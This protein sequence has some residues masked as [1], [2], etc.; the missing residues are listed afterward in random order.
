MKINQ[1]PDLYIEQYLLGELPENLR[2]EIDE[3]MQHS[4]ELKDRIS[5]MEKSNQDILSVYPADEIVPGIIEKN[6]ISKNL[7]YGYSKNQNRNIDHKSNGVIKNLSLS[8]KKFLHTTS[9]ISVRR[10]TL[11]IA[12][13]AMMIA[14]IVF[15]LPGIRGIYNTEKNYDDTIRIKG[16]ESKLLLYRMKGRD[17]EE[18]KNFDT[19]QQGDV[20]QVGYIA[21]GNFNYGV[22]LSIDGRGTVTIHLPQNSVPGKSLVMNKRTLL[23]K[24]YELDDSPSF[25]RFIMILSPDPISIDSVMEKAKKLAISRESALNGSIDEKKGSIEFSITINKP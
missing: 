20:I 12:S 24:S 21:A 5:E 3:L 14:V 7:N 15:M 16:L 13:A 11:S 9:S 4:S 22:I 1:I 10:Y 25:E 6:I 8:L 2:K 18:L 17:V 23:D 19:A